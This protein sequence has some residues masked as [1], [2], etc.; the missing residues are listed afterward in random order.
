MDTEEQMEGGKVMKLNC[1][2]ATPRYKGRMIVHKAIK[3]A[4]N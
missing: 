4:W 2:L 1:H 3:V